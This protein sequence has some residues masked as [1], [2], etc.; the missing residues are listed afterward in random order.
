MHG[1][2]IKKL[3]QTQQVEKGI[4]RSN[5]RTLLSK[6]EISNPSNQSSRYLLGE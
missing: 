4:L 2:D 1:L 3:S 5:A 6:I